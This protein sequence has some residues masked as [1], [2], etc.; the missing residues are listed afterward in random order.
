MGWLFSI[1]DVLF[2]P[3]LI[4]ERILFLDAAL[5]LHP[6]KNKHPKAEIAFKLVLQVRYIP[7]QILGLI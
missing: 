3:V 2:L 5:Q 7:F 6:D 4:R 1:C